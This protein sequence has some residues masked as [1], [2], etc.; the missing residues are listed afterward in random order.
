MI[1]PKSVETPHY[2]IWTDALH[3]RHLARQASNAWDRGTY[4]RWTISSAWTAFELACEDATSATGLGRRFKEKLDAAIRSKGIA[5]LD[6]GQ[7]V[8]Q[9]V[10][11]IHQLRKDYVHPAIPQ[12]RLFAQVGEADKAITVLRS[13]IRDLYARL[14]NPSPEWIED[15]GNPTL[16]TGLHGHATLIRAGVQSDDPNTIRITYAFQGTE[17]NSDF[18]PPGTDPSPFMLD[19]IRKILVPISAV[20]AYRGETL[21]EEIRIKMR[22][23]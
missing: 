13:A 10:R 14:G 9:Q 11:Q 17:Y 4:V 16:P 1:L 22:G 21:L 5:P 23:S 12:E 2:H 8:W 3:G 7:G 19:L 20:R 6:W 15:D 18:L